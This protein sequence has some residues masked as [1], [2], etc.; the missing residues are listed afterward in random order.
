MNGIDSATSLFLR[1]PREGGRCFGRS[2]RA[3]DSPPTETGEA[4]EP[5]ALHA[6]VEVAPRFLFAALGLASPLEDY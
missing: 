1:I 5:L 6:A 2:D 4:L 3:P